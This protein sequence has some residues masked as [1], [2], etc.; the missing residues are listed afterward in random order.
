VRHKSA[1]PLLYKKRPKPELVS[2]TP[3]PVTESDESTETRALA[4]LITESDALT[5]F[6]TE[7]N[8]STERSAHALEEFTWSCNY[9][10]PRMTVDD[11]QKAFVVV[12]EL[13]TESKAEAA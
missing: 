3:T 2:V 1:A 12:R 5:E 13:L 8:L 9:W 10:L 7:G 4:E 6:T 11:Q